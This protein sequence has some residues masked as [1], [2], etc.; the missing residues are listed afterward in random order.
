MTADDLT[1][2]QI[3]ELREALLRESGNQF[4]ADTDATGMALYDL[5][6]YGP[7]L[8]ESAKIVRAIAR[9]RCVELINARKEAA[10]TETAPNL[11]SDIGAWPDDRLLAE[12][13]LT[14]EACEREPDPFAARTYELRARKLE[15]QRKLAIHNRLE[16]E[17]LDALEVAVTRIALLETALRRALN[18]WQA[19]V[20]GSR[21]GDPLPDIASLRAVLETHES[22][23]AAILA[24]IA[25]APP[26]TPRA[27]R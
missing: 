16:T 15:L 3:R 5:D 14:R 17:R 22:A 6:R 26:R 13:A 10:V 4:T 1:D 27:A 11:D 19:V 7:H 9:D 25:H 24:A 21:Y 23:E 20:T 18:G 8:R 12:L 2:D